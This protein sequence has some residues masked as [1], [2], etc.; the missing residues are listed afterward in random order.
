MPDR[1]IDAIGKSEA[2]QW[3]STHLPKYRGNP[4]Q[5]ISGSIGKLPAGAIVYATVHKVDSGTFKVILNGETFLLKGLPT[6]LDGKQIAFMARHNPTSG[7]GLELIWS[8]NA[9]TNLKKGEQQNSAHVLSSL[10]KQ[11]QKQ[12]ERPLSAKVDTIAAG[13]MRITVEYTDAKAG[14][15]IKQQLEATAINHLKAGEQIRIKLHTNTRQ[16]TIEILAT[17]Q[18][19]TAS[20]PANMSAMSPPLLPARFSLAPG[21]L[22]TA[23]VQKRLSN[24]HV[25]LNIQGK[26]VESAAPAQV[27]QGDLLTLR[28]G[29]SPADFQL[30]SI[31]SQVDNKA[32]STL[33]ANMAIHQ[34][35]LAQ[36][37]GALHNALTGHSSTL[38]P[39]LAR[40]MTMLESLLSAPASTSDTSITAEKLAQLMTNS[41]S[42]LESKLL[43]MTRANS[44]QPPLQQ[45]LKTLLLQLTQQLQNSAQQVTWMRHLTELSQHTTARIESNQA[46]NVL[47]AM[48]GDPIRFELPMLIN[49]QWVSVM[50]SVEQQPHYSDDQADGEQQEHQGGVFNILFSMQ[51]SGLGHVRVDANI[52]TNSVHARIHNDN[53]SSNQFMVQHL[54]RLESRLRNLGFD[55]VYLVSTQ[56]EP[57]TERQQQFEQLTNMRPGSVSMLDIRV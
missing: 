10:P 21:D 42:S 57:P 31:Q 13:K 24:G 17:N 35:P 40:I 20:T 38:S 22:V 46:L 53:E 23:A 54:N 5:I 19:E 1:R 47:A 43:A 37:V 28:M 56:T 55:E 39:D 50:M 51:L 7:G 52:S 27:K 2:L 48:H 36:Q 49:H 30:L 11:L 14:I 32:L 15:P 44:G 6:S 3:S 16:P 41:G 34:I 33:K 29:T 45:D 26:V 8:G 12:S 4:L 25:Q 18:P 9:H